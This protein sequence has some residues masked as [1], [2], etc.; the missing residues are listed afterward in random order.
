MPKKRFSPPK[1]KAPMRSKLDWSGIASVEIVSRELRP[2]FEDGIEYPDSDGKPLG[3][4]GFHVDC[5]AALYEIF[6]RIY[7]RYPDIHVACRLFLY[8]E[9]GNP[10]AR[11]DPDIM[12]TKGVGSHPRH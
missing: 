4:T 1:K 2:W 7:C 8:Y 5:T 11:K 3:E 6:K 10:R 12:V 9:K